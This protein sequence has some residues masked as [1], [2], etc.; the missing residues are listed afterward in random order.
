MK[1]TIMI[2]IVLLFAN[3]KQKNSQVEPAFYYWKSNWCLTHDEIQQLDILRV[4][5]LYVKFFE[6]ECDPVFFAAPYTKSSLRIDRILDYWIGDTARVLRTLYSPLVI[7]TIFIKNEVFREISDLQSDELADNIVFLVKKHLGER[8]SQ[9]NIVE[10]Q[11]DCDWT[12][13]TRDRYFKFLKQLDFKLNPFGVNWSDIKV[14]LSCTLR[15]YPYKYPQLMGVPPVDKVM[16]MC[17]NMTSPLT[18]D[19]KNSILDNT[20]LKS[21]IKGVKRYP[22]HID[23]ALPLF[24]WVMAFQNGSF[25]GVFRYDSSI[26]DK[27]KPNLER[28]NPSE[29]P[30]WFDVQEDIELDELYLRPGDLLKIEE[31]TPDN[32]MQSIDLLK[33]YV[34]LDPTIT[35]ALFHLDDNN[36]KIYSYETIA[37]FYN[38]F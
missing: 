35:V 36:T 3:C 33:K 7:P 1:L 28:S 24:S 15:L 4:K 9:H 20:E 8:Y 11:I 14:L 13:S 29:A 27:V 2:L 37:T 25:V 5:K 22:L 32:I 31:I 19:T 38:H 16:L 10:L 23:I 6:V 17:Y 30:L 21:Y 12:A 34:D 18:S 26:A